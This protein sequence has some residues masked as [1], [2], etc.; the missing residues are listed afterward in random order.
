MNT[1]LLIWSKDIETP[2][3]INDISLCVNGVEI[4]I[5]TNKNSFSH[6]LGTVYMVKINDLVDIET[7]DG[8]GYLRFQ[9]FK[10]RY[11]K[12]IF[13]PHGSIK[14][15]PIESKDILV[16]PN[17]MSELKDILLMIS[18]LKPEDL[19]LVSSLIRRLLNK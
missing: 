16:T 5:V 8:K 7:V 12:G 15:K 9:K 6:K 13:S 1:D 19:N 4:G 11:R 18:E 2:I 17:R 14:E 10:I 3:S